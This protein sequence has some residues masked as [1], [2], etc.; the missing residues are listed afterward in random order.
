MPFIIVVFENCSCSSY[1]GRKGGEQ[2]VNISNS[3][4]SVGSAAHELGHALGLWHEQSRPDRDMYIN[5]MHDNIIS[6]E[7]DDKNF[8]ILSES[9]FS[10]VPP[11][12]YDIESIMHYGKQAFTKDQ[13]L[14]T[15]EVREDVEWD[16][17]DDPTQMGQRDKISHKDAL[18]VKLLYGCGDGTLVCLRSPYLQ[19][20]PHV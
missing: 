10:K 4:P 17:C 5:V 15:I 7:I 9:E 8:G 2:F 14:N 16:M 19:L 3:C 6:Q 1:I 20:H 18:R 13:S 12:S 11:V